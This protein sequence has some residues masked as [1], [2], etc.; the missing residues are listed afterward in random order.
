MICTGII[1]GSHML[2]ATARQM[3]D[4]VIHEWEADHARDPDARPYY[5]GRLHG[6]AA[7]A[8]GWDQQCVCAPI[9][10]CHLPSGAGS[11]LM[12]V[13]AGSDQR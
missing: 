8:F 9:H 12:A 10:N 11:T 6:W 7:A 2:Q 1:C 4:T 3:A 13:P 5:Q